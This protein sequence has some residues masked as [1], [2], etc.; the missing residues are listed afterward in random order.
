MKFYDI[1]KK[2]EHTAHLV[3]CEEHLDCTS[4]DSDSRAVENEF[5]EE[6]DFCILDWASE[7]E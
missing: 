4:I 6:C 1:I 5:A 7:E 3:L 2:G